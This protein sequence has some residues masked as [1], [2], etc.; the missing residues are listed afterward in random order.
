MEATCVLA[1]PAVVCRHCGDRCGGFAVESA[2]GPFCCR[3]CASVFALLHSSGLGAFYACEATPGSTQRRT[4]HTIDELAAFDDPR[5]AARVLGIDTAGLSCAVFA[6]PD[7]HCAS[8][9]WLIE[10]LWRI[11]ARIA[12]AEVDLLRRSVQV[13]FHA[14]RMRLREVAELLAAAGYAPELP[15][16]AA[17]PGPVRSRRRDYLQLAVAGFAFGNAMLFSIP[18]YVNGAPLEA[19]FQQVFDALN[20]VLATPVLLYSASGYLGRAWRAL[21]MLRLTIDVPIALGILALYGR[22]LAD[23]VSGRGPGF[24][25][26]FAGLVFFLLIGR[27]FQQQAFDRIAFDRTFRSFLP[28]TVRV[29]QDG[30]WR[31]TAIDALRVGDV[32]SLRPQEVAPADAEV[33]DDGGTVDYAFVTGESTPV[34]VSRGDRVLAGGRVV[35]R[36]LRLRVAGLVE[37]THL[38][39]LWN[40]PAFSTG[41]RHWM[42]GVSDRFGAWFTIATLAVAAAGAIAW[43]PDPA[44]AVQVASAVLIIACPCALTLAAP[45]ALGTAMA[46]LAP[47]GLYLKSAAVLLDLSRVDTVVF[48]KTGTLTSGDVRAEAPAGLSSL[49]WHR[50][51]QLASQSAH[52]VSRGI[53]GDLVAGPAAVDD[54]LELAGLGV[55]GRVDGHDVVI[56]SAAFVSSAIAEAIDEPPSETGSS[57]AVAIDG[58]FRGWVRLAAPARAGVEGAAAALA[59]RHEISLLSGDTGADAGRWRPIFGERLR[60]RQSPDDKLAF[61]QAR[62]AEGRHVLMVGDGLNDAGALAAADVGLAVSDDAACLV[63]ACDALIRGRALEW[64]PALLR[65]AREARQ[66]IVL[67]FAVSV[68]YN[69]IGL[70]LALQGRLTPLATA[71]LMPVSSLTVIG[72]S[73]GA[74][75]WLA[76]RVPSCP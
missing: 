61:V 54:H 22:S 41:R 11:D 71:V 67:C 4:R 69:V 58:R 24:L 25:D 8:C 5:V 70:T 73:A 9:V 45:V 72:L 76:R 53:A 55:R 30:G 74:M 19:P 66:V 36:T 23:I 27:L 56:G 6:V 2:D 17:A 34:R 35:E 52:P 10:R 43:W 20:V 21:A 29:E 37:H 26:S 3:G 7:L 46:R 42:A 33:H 63:P 44:M 1:P 59:R 39:R 16:E 62:K 68:V 14:D 48:D 13:W 57:A 60:F 49:E 50:V 75:R 31:R 15:R 12:R 65:Y 51:R 40:H 47:R 38:A 28:L 18:R 64:L 32:F